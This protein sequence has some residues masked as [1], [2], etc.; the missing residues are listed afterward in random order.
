MHMWV[1][2]DACDVA[3]ANITTLFDV[4]ILLGFHC[5]LPLL[6]LLNG[7]IEMAKAQDITIS[8]MLECG[9]KIRH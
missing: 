3:N 9:N 7:L 4:W 8:S 6:E 2:Q 5:L 1:D